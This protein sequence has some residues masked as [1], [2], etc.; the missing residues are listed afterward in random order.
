[1]KS[2][3]LVRKT[4]LARGTSTLK[5]TAFARS[6]TPKPRRTGPPKVRDTPRPR[7]VPSSLG[8]IHMG[9]V[10]ELGCIVCLN[11]RLGRSAAECHHARCFAGGGQK[12]TDFHTIPLC[13]LHH[14]LGGSGVALHAGRQTFA[15]IFGTEP[16]LLLQVLQ[17]L[18]FA[19][20][21]EQLARPDLGAL[22]YPERV[23]A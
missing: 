20:F 8:L 14:R 7:V 11:L 12:S 16:E 1:M 5:R 6:S 10:A 4:T 19:I 23:L 18:G 17:M 3:A 2:T 13:P 15:R 9:R 21:P 22:L